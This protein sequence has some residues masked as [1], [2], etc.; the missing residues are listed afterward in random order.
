LKYFIILLDIFFEKV[1]NC[2]GNFD[3]VYYK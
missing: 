1:N 2:R 3:L